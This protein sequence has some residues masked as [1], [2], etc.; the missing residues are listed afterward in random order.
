MKAIEELWTLWKLALAAFVLICSNTVVAQTSYKVTDLGALHDGVV[1]C[2]MGLN[3]RGWTESMDGYLDASGNFRGRAVVNVPGLKIDLGTLGGPDSWINW[4]G[5]NERGEAVGLAETQF[6]DADGEDFCGF[7]TGL[8]CRPFVWRNGDM[9]AL[10]TLGGNNGLASAI[11]SRGQIVG[12]AEI[13]ATDSGCPP[14]HIALPVL[15]EKGK[16]QRLPTVANDPDGFALGI[17][18]SG[19]A[20]GATGTCTA[21]VHA[22]LWQNSA[23]T[24]LPNLGSTSHNA[25]VA[26]NNQ[27]QIVGDSS[28]DATT[29]YAVLWQNGTIT[30]LGTLPGDFASW[31]TGINDKGQVVGSTFDTNFNFSH[32]FVWQNGVMTDLNTLFPADSNLYATMANKINSRGQISGMATVLSGEDAGNI[33]AFL[34]TPVN[35]SIAKSVAEVAAA[36]SA[37]KMHENV[38]KQLFQRLGLGRFV[39]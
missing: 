38:R 19:E 4:G 27:R 5:I 33:H 34:A 14:Y 1:G 36:N 21:E 25:A 24:E 2:A 13:T 7:G 39:R 12:Q 30:N 11:N 15:W 9:T 20:V 32:A 8:T 26:I 22:V 18:D 31:A 10:R 16:V 6:P 17:N 28:P 3:N 29:M 37:S 35:V 23:A